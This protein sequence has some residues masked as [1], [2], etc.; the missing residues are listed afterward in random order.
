VRGGDVSVGGGA[1]RDKVRRGGSCR[2]GGGRR[3]T[4]REIQAGGGRS[5]PTRKKKLK[6]Q[7]RGVVDELAMVC[8]SGKNRN[9]GE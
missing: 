4:T 9:K 1:G 8:K 6:I 7:E 5:E 3:Y 2:A